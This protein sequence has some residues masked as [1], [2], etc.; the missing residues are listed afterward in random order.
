MKLIEAEPDA[1]LKRWRNIVASI[2]DIEERALKN[3]NT[4]PST[5]LDLLRYHGGRVAVLSEL[6]M[7]IDLVLKSRKGD[8]A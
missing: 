7:Q 5:S 8:K 6:L 1:S 3:L 4:T 2:A